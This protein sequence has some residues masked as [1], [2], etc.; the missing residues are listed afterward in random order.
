MMCTLP[1]DAFPLQH[2]LIAFHQTTNNLSYLINSRQPM[3]A[4]ISNPFVEAA[5]SET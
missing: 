1:A 2:E 5:R 4:I 3:M